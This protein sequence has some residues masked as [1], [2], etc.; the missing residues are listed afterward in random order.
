MDANIRMGFFA[1]LGAYVLWG[2]LPLYFKTLGHVPPDLMLAHRILWS[3]PTGILLVVAAARWR[4]LAQALTLRRIG[5]LGISA[6]LIGVNWLV[7]IWAVGQERVMEASLGYYINPLVNVII[8]ALFLSEKLRAQQW[9]AIGIAALGVA[10]MTAGLGRLPWV[11]LVLCI[12]FA[13]YSLIRKRVAIDGRGGCLVEAAILFPLAA[14]W[15]TQFASA[16]G[17]VWA[18]GE[19]D[20]ALLVAAGPITAAPLIF[21]A[22]AA[23]RL[24]LSTLGMMQYLGPTLQFLIALAF[25][26][27]FGWTQAAAFACIWIALA[28]FTADGLVQS[29]HFKTQAAAA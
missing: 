2:L 3:A 21:F 12:S 11:A 24:R 23:K 10:I 15:M 1:G 18:R 25:G 27:T 6:T 19:W 17:G 20:I 26:E 14:V 5:W 16:G 9:A 13:L 4:D 8:G 28:L 29:R 22:V 7:Y